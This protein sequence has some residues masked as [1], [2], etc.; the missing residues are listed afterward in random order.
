[1]T[2]KEILL[3]V[4]AAVLLAGG[5]MG[6]IKARSVPSVMSAAVFALVFVL[7]A[8]DALTLPWLAETTLALLAVLMGVRWAKSKKFMPAGLIAVLAAVVFV[9]QFVL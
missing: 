5:M 9:L 3:L 7:I 1:M 4:F 6:W 2:P 8:T